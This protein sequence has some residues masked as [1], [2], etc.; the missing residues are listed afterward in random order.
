MTLAIDPATLPDMLRGWLGAHHAF[1]RDAEALV[2]AVADLHPTDAEAAARLAG[3]FSITTR[4]L[5]LH[6]TS[7][8]ELVFAELIDRAPA[9]AGVVM[10]MSLEHVDLDDVVEDIGRA[11]ATLSGRSSRADEVHG[12]LVE[13]AAT[14]QAVLGAHLD[15]E[16]E[17]ALP[18]M[19]R[20]YTESELDA[21]GEAHLARVGDEIATMVPWALSAMLPELASERLATLPVEVQPQ[22]PAW[23]QRFEQR[24]APMLARRAHSVAA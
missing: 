22:V 9:F 3:A 5:E 16:E 11:L 20:W 17:Q 8:D 14:L 1:R 23:S 24:F 15:A 4:M 2:A 6:H 13:Q 7:E 21:I 18:M 12:R 19:L 10:T